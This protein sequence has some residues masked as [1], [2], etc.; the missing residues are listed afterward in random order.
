MRK[1]V[2]YCYAWQKKIAFLTVCIL[3]CFQ[4]GVL[5]QSPKTKTITASLQ[6]ES[7]GQR[8][9]TLQQIS[10]ITIAFEEKDVASWK[11]SAG[12]YKNE[13]LMK[14][15]D[16]TLSGLP[17]RF[18]EVNGVI[19][20]LTA[21]GKTQQQQ[22]GKLAGQLLDAHSA[23][24]IIGATLRIGQHGTTTDVKGFYT[25]SLP[26]GSYTL[27]I[28]YIGYTTKQVKDVAIIA[29]RTQELNL[30]MS[31]Q[32]GTLK[33]VEVV[34]NMR[35]ESIAALYVKQK[36]SPAISDGISA[37]QIRRTPDN[38]VAQV[39]KR[40]SGLTVQDN[41]FV[42]VR[43]MSERYN[44]VQLNGSILPSTE[45]NRRNFNFDIIPSNLIDNVVVNKTFTPD[46]PG[47][48]SGGLVQVNTIDVPHENFLQITAG[49]GF[50]NNST[51]K[52]FKSN[53]RYN[54]DFFGGGSER[55]WL[56]KSWKTN[57]YNQ[58]Y[59]QDY[60]AMAEINKNIPARWSTYNFTAKPNQNY[61][62]S[63]GHSFRLKNSNSIGLV[64][65]GMYRHD[66][67][68]ENIEGI[69]RAVETFEPGKNNI[70]KFITSL[71]GLASLSWQ[72]KSSKITWRNLYNRRFTNNYI[73]QQYFIL[74]GG[75]NDHARETYANILQN[76]LYQSRL[77]G[78]HLLNKGGLKLDWFADYNKLNRN[79]PDDRLTKALILGTDETSG[80]PLLDYLTFITDT[81]LTNGGLISTG[82][83][84]EKKNIGFNLEFPFKWNEKNQK[85]KVGYW[86]TFR[87]ATFKMVTIKPMKSPNAPDNF[88]SM[89]YG[90]PVE[91]LYGQQNFANDYLYYRYAYA[92]AGANAN[93][94]SGSQDIHAGYL[95]LD[96]NPFDKLRFIGGARMEYSQMDVYTSTRLSTGDPANPIRWVDSVIRYSEP[97]WLPSAS[98]I[99]SLTPKVNIRAAYS[100]TIARPD[101]RERSYFRY[102]DIYQRAMLNGNGGLEI[103]TTDNYDLR[104][105]Y[106]PGAGE[107]ISVS[108]FYKKFIKPVELVSYVTSGTAQYT[109]LFFNLENSK[110]GGFEVD[111]R[112]SLGFI[113]SRAEWLQQ[114]YLSGNFSWFKGNV[115]YDP[116]KLAAEAQGIELDSNVATN[117]SRNRPLQGLSP[118]V[119]NG[120]INYLGRYFGLNLVYNRFGR[121][122]KIAGVDE[123]N[124]EYENPR[125]VLDAQVSAKLLKQRLEIRLNASD[126]LNQYFIVYKNMNFD[127]NGSPIINKNNPGGY[128]KN[129]DWTLY[130]SRLGSTYSATITYKF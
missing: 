110:I 49:M 47:E 31:A 115:T 116:N 58:V 36:N 41:K 93:Q 64:I 99:Y 1:Q 20:I 104:V 126:L 89:F 16:Y 43:G 122:I 77:E 86:G 95:L 45:P 124:D 4:F 120:G 67:E 17:L 68:I 107:V 108:G 103:S 118:Y 113:D 87:N 123:Y 78:E 85:L 14:V 10:G 21:T 81:Y 35:R 25:L 128:D 127:E 66:E 28:S 33:G 46:L 38:N 22:E 52:E 54:A 111:F 27:E 74:G 76:T 60:P 84:E 129:T 19:V 75:G 73:E 29:G 63:L 119:I 6:D 12:V 117:P 26:Q 97:K 32:K 71:G 125:D 37:E 83:N 62:L 101:F 59:L 79:Q 69:T 23:E 114:L 7:L 40:V 18:K 92:S 53:A 130:K 13:P 82:L 5:A 57:E 65:S 88:N 94:Y 112:K 56:N 98:L 34:A 72:G 61:Q 105:E 106:Y 100:Q 48:F 15:L 44:N 11:A 9:K 24:P 30:T 96:L 80:K 2:H 121:R 90:K 42:T 70:Y 39:L 51:G 55:D 109:Q 8:L 91:E 50:N 3:L 102:Y